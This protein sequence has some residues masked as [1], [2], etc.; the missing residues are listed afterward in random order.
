MPGFLDVIPFLLL[1]VAIFVALQLNLAKVD[2]I[3]FKIDD[4]NLMDGPLHNR[5]RLLQKFF[6]DSLKV[7]ILEYFILYLRLNAKKSTKY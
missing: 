4:G 3:S 7:C 6:M 5:I 2:T 1:D